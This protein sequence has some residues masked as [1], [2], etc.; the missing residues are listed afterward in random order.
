MMAEVRQAILDLQ[1]YA[2]K[3][4][5]GDGEKIHRLCRVLTNSL[6]EGVCQCDPMGARHYPKPFCAECG[7]PMEVKP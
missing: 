1:E 6:R 2:N 7:K 4:A 3:L 5:P